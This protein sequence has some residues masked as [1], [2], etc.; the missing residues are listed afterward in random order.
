MLHQETHRWTDAVAAKKSPAEPATPVSMIVYRSR[1]RI[2]PS[3]LELELI[4]RKAQERNGAEGL[5]G[6]L[7]YDQGCFFQWLEGPEDGLARVWASIQADPRHYD[8]EVLRQESMPKRFFGEWDMRLARRARG[9]LDAALTEL[10]APR[11]IHKYLRVQAAGLPQSQWDA[12][13]ADAVLPRLRE[14]LL[15]ASVTVAPRRVI[16]HANEGAAAELA[17]LLLAVDAGQ[18]GDYISGLVAEGASIETLFEEVFEPAARCLGGLWEFDDCSEFQATLGMVRLQVEVRRLGAAFDHPLYAV[19]PGHAVLVATQPGEPH[20]LGVAMSSELFCRDG[21]D[22]SCEFPATNEGLRDLV[23][24]RWFDVLDLSLSSAMRREEQLPAMR[25]TIRMA[26]AASLNP[27]L[28][29]MVG[30]R[31]FFESPRAY[32]DAGA[33]VGCLTVVETIPAA[34]RLLDSLAEREGAMRASIAPTRLSDDAHAAASL[35]LFERRFR[36]TVF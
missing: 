31:A 2:L 27:A 36:S 17:A 4:L 9:K 32:H 16:W 25:T 21:W 22:V 18:A 29:V 23:H 6:L 30:G 10:T 28:A 7:I 1:V 26:Q 15:G 11:E 8:I 19:R 13:F 35:R 14:R 3:E 20:G 33:H 24:E 12:V 5:T 34:Q